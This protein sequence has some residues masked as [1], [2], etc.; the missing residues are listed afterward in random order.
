MAFVTFV[1]L[2]LIDGF[3]PNTEQFSWT[4]TKTYYNNTHPED[5]LG[6]AANLK[7]SIHHWSTAGGIAGRGILLDY[8]TYAQRHNIVYDPHVPYSIP[9]SDL[10]DCGKEQG[11][12]IRPAAL[13]GDI[14]I[15]DMLFIRAGFVE[16]YYE[17]SD[18]E[19]EMMG[20]E[21]FMGSN[22][23]HDGGAWAGVEQSEEMKT[24][25]HDCYFA[26]V[27]GDQPAFECFPPQKGEFTLIYAVV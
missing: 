16:R 22:G 2:P 3:C 17:K 14:K 15:G 21:K 12:D 5:I 1:N 18:A 6:P 26:T 13:G 10:V 24:W 25:L 4:K 20:T 23:T 27:A 19:R 8:R 7:C 9:Y 11:I